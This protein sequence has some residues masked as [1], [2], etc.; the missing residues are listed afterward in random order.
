M[1]LI[2]LMIKLPPSIWEMTPNDFMKLGLT[3]LIVFFLSYFWGALGDL[4]N[5]GF[6]YFMAVAFFMLGLLICFAAMF[7]LV[8]SL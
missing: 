8:W 3:G 6:F 1:N 2:P 4:F 7:G 5:N